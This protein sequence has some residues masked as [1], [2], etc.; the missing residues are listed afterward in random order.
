MNVCSHECAAPESYYITREF[1]VVVKMS[2]LHSLAV[3]GSDRG[4]GPVGP[5]IFLSKKEKGK[6]KERKLR[7]FSTFP[8]PPKD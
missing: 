2:D 4:S 8:F 1:G 7:H 6:K 3:D 5:Q